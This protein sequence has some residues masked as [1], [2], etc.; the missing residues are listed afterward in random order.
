MSQLINTIENVITTLQPRPSWDE[1]FMSMALLISSRSPCERLHVGCVLVKDNRVISAGYNGF[2]SS[3]P[4][5]SCVV[6]D[7]EQNT[8]HAEQNCIADCASRGISTA[9]ATAYVTHFP[10]INCTKMLCA[11]DVSKIIYLNDYKNNPLCTSLLMMKG[12]SVY[13]M[14]VHVASVEPIGPIEPQNTINNT[15]S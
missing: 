13:K 1:Y 10:C 14:P 11:S 9:N 8:V 2:L 12:V 4:H 5:I 7:S 6:N 3:V 15:T